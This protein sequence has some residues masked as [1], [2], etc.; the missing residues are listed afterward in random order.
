MSLLIPMPRLARQFLA[1]SVLALHATAMLCGPCLHGLP[2]L[3]H[4]GGV[5]LGADVDHG[6]NPAKAPHGQGHDCPICH[7]FSQGQLPI[8]TACVPAIQHVYV[9][10]RE[11]SYA[12]VFPGQPHATSPRAPPV[13]RARLS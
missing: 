6:Q 8:D 9:W 11:T 13:S 12:C 5:T 2:G 10:R 4:A 7:F 3:G 1:V